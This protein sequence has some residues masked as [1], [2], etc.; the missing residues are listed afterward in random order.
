MKRKKNMIKYSSMNEKKIEFRSVKYWLLFIKLRWNNYT[1][2]TN[3][4][5]YKMKPTVFFTS[6]NVL[7][8]DIKSQYSCQTSLLISRLKLRY[9]H[10]SVTTRPHLKNVH[11]WLWILH[12]CK[13][14]FVKTVLIFNE[15]LLKSSVFLVVLI[16]EIL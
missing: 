9:N 10:F 7:P 13:L 16:S 11:I 12:P 8:A 6:R 1:A 2:K 4:W 15:T 14:L 5:A 3:F